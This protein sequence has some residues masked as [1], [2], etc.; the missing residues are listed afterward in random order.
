MGYILT[1]W[2][3]ESFR[4]HFSQDWFNSSRKKIGL[5]WLF[6]SIIRSLIYKYHQEDVIPI[7]EAG[8]SLARYS[9]CR[10]PSLFI[11]LIIT[12][13]PDCREREVWIGC[14]CCR[15]EIV[16]SGLMEIVNVKPSR[17]YYLP[18]RWCG[19]APP[20]ACAGWRG[21]TAAVSRTETRRSWRPARR[22]PGPRTPGT[23][24][25]TESL[26]NLNNNLM[27]QTSCCKQLLTWALQPE[28]FGILSSLKPKRFRRSLTRLELRADDAVVVVAKH[29]IKSFACDE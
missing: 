22:W 14:P 18:E 11:I 21:L 9:K 23:S 13:G 15:L 29:P 12:A 10:R 6:F 8:P 25:W 7:T 1:V 28:A 19:G 5:A 20:L 27:H 3:F 4:Y 16:S 26:D 24:A 17:C 2:S